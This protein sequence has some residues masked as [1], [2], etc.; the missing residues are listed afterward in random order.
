MRAMNEHLWSNDVV[1]AGNAVSR[2]KKEDNDDVLSWLL[3]SSSAW[4]C[5]ETRLALAQLHR[6]CDTGL[7][8]YRNADCVNCESHSVK[9]GPSRNSEGYRR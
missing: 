2:I 1:N 6:P 5:E 4:Y 7:A 8:L 3:S 9:S